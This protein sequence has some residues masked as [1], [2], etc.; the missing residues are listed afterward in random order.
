MN[1]EPDDEPDSSGDDEAPSNH[2]GIR[3][4][5]GAVPHRYDPP[6]HLKCDRLDGGR[7][8]VFNRI[9][10]RAAAAGCAKWKGI[11]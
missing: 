9:A 6:A 5:D 2:R 3:Q 10:F 8:Q 7:H 1:A 11:P 4:D